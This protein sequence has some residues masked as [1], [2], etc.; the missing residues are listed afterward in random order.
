MPLIEVNRTK[1][2]LVNGE[3]SGDTLLDTNTVEK[4]AENVKIPASTT[5]T[6]SEVLFLISLTIV[7]SLFYP[8]KK[9]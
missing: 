6:Q 2:D 4:N 9:E 8:E 1:S 5:T 3:E 7:T